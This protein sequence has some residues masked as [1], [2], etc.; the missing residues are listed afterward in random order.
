MKN[1]TKTNLSFLK[2]DGGFCTKVPYNGI[3]FNSDHMMAEA[4]L[5]NLTAKWPKTSST[6]NEEP[7]LG[8]DLNFYLSISG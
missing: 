6:K 5:D 4:G 1:Y 2:T 8:Y 7:E 3:L